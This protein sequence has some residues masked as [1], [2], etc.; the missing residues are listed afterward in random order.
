MA[1]WNELTTDQQA[2]ISELLRMSANAAGVQVSGQVLLRG[3]GESLVIP[4]TAV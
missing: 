4:A 1:T 3:E 2:K